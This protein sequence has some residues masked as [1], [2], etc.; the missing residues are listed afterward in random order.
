MQLCGASQPI[1]TWQSREQTSSLL[2]STIVIC[3]DRQSPQNLLRLINANAPNLAVK[4]HRHRAVGR[5]RTQQYVKARFGIGQV[6]QHPHA[7]DE[8]KFTEI[9]RWQIEQIALHEFDAFEASLLRTGSCNFDGRRAQVEVNN[10]CTNDA[11]LAQLFG[12]KNGAVASATTR[13]QHPEACVEYAFAAKAMM[14]EQVE[15]IKPG[16]DQSRSLISRVACRV[17]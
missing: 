5:E 6:V 12:D 11:T 1:R 4:Q 2:D 9:H 17:R 8:I 13:N 15:I 7:I 16:S 10:A 3:S 14:I